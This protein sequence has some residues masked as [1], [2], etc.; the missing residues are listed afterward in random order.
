MERGEEGKSRF[1]PLAFYP[2]P[3][4]S[5]FFPP[6]RRRRYDGGPQLPPSSNSFA[7][8]G[9]SPFFFPPPWACWSFRSS[10][11][12]SP[13]PA[14]FP[15]SF[16][17]T[18]LLGGGKKRERRLFFQ[19]HKQASLPSRR[20][21]KVTAGSAEAAPR[22]TSAAAHG[23]NCHADREDLESFPPHANRSTI[24]PEEP[25]WDFTFRAL[26]RSRWRG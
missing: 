6:R 1:Y 23:V 11:P 2:L 14:D 5:L 13:S 17:L 8:D 20:R 3:S 19:C 21:L 25:M 7:S 24:F 15:H 9:R 16:A 12:P 10:P 18:V 22:S 26:L 4:P